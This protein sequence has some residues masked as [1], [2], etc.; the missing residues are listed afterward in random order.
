MRRCTKS[1]NRQIRL[2]GR[3]NGYS[4]DV[5]F[6]TTNSPGFH[7]LSNQACSGP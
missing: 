7:V 3:A 2:Y 6:T 1:Q 5:Q 4:P